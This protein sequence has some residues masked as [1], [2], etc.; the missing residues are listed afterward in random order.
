MTRRNE[1]CIKFKNLDLII[2]QTFTFNL[3]WKR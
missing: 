2:E 3:M 1:V